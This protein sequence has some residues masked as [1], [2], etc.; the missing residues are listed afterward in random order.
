MDCH[1]CAN[2]KY[3]G[4]AYG[5]CSHPSHVD[6]RFSLKEA[7]E[8]S[9]NGIRPYNKQICPDFV[10]KKKCSNCWYWT[11]GMYFADG[12]TPA[13]KGFCSLSISKTGEVCELWR[14]G[15]T[16]WKKK[17]GENA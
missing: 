17:Q 9:K 15:R 8:R 3:D 1:R 6:V 7:R 11:R 12:E 14:A 10:M 5:R 16:S 2:L 4:C 13:I